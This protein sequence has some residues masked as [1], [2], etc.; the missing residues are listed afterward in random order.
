LCAVVYEMLTGRRA[1]EG[2]DVSDTL[3]RILMKEPDWTA[4]PT[5]VQPAMTTVLRRCLQ[6]DPKA[7]SARRRRSGARARGRVPHSLAGE[8]ID[9]ILDH[10]RIGGGVGRGGV[11]RRAGEPR[12]DPLQ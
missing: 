12:V 1:F 4:L 8:D 9:A 10:T 7:S 11:R 5:T 3:A 2:E 6:K